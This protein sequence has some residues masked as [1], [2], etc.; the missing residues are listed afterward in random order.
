MRLQSPSSLIGLFLVALLVVGCGAPQ[1]SAA[2]VASSSPVS[3]PATPTAAAAPNTLTPSF[4]RVGAPLARFNVVATYAHD[5][6][7]YTQG[8]V[9]FGNDTVYEGT[10][11]WQSSALRE[12]TLSSGQVQRQVLLTTVAPPQAG[13]QPA[14]G[15]GI[16]V[17]GNRIFQLTWQ[18]GFGLIYDRTT[19]QLVGRFTYPPPGR[20]MPVEGWG[21]T[22]D[23]SRLIMSDGSGTLYFVDPVA[24]ERDGVLSISGTVAAHDSQGAL[25]ELNELEYVNGAVY[26]NIWNCDLIARIDATTG[27]VQAYLDLHSLRA[28]LPVTPNVVPEVLNGIAYDAVSGRLLVTGKWWPSLFVLTL[29]VA[30]T[31]LPLAQKIADFRLQILD[32][33][34]QV[35]D[36][37]RSPVAANLQFKI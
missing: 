9:Y 17:A 19:F 21:L 10:G 1:P 11:Y 25:D 18:S 4:C 24:T 29:P 30:F 13:A 23:G 27:A 12:A 32:C 33:R 26:A 5:P 7:A 37:R 15:E 8:L 34:L 14:F 35:A 6:S 3:A 16:A 22:Y 36:C 31:Y 20:Q 28:L 2:T